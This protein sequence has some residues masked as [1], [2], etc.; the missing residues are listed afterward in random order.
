MPGFGGC[1]TRVP[2]ST[3]SA[4]FEVTGFF[5]VEGIVAV[6]APDKMRSIAV[7]AHGGAGKATLIESLLFQSRAISSRGST[8]KGSAVMITE[9][10]EAARKIAITPHIGHFTFDDVAVF[11]VDAPGYF[12]FLESTRGILPGIDGAVFIFTGI[13]GVKPETERLWNMLQ[14]AQIPVIGFVN[15]MDDPNADLHQAL[16]KIEKTL[17]TALQPLTLP[18]GHGPQF[19]GVIDLL[20]KSASTVAD[21]KAKKIDLPE[22][23]EYSTARTQLIEKIAE[24]SDVLIEKY[25]EG[26]ELSDAELDQGLRDAVLKRSFVPMLCGAADKGI[27]VDV[28]LES[29]AR[30]LPSPADRAALRPFVG[31]ESPT[32]TEEIKR[33]P[34]PEQPFSAFVIKTTIDP[35]SGKLSVVRVVSGSIKSNQPVYNSTRQMKQKAGHVYLLQGKELVQVEFLT[36]GQIGAIAKLEETHTSDT[37]CD[38]DDQCYFP[39]VKFATAPISYAVEAEGKAEDKIASGLHKLMEEDPSLHVYR[40]EQTHEMILSGMGQTHIEVTLERLARKFGGKAKLKTPRVPYRETIR[41]TVK[42]QGKLKKQSGGHG[43]FANCW[44]EVG[45]LPRDGG[46][47][48]EDQI[49]GGVIPRQF[50][51]SIKKG[52]QDSMGKGVLGGYPV[53]DVKVA[54][55]DGSYHDVDSSD[56]AFQVAGSLGFKSAL[57]TASSVLLEPIML[58]EVIVPEECTGDIMKDISSRRG[59]VLN[60]DSKGD[61][62]QIKADI[63]LAEVLDY[64]HSLSA[65]TSGRGIYTIEL[66][67]YREVPSNISEKVL[68]AQKAEAAASA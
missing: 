54:V 11:V 26:A 25:L 49:V 24:S 43:Q 40:D 47:E 59:R 30:Y 7:I 38:P 41:K 16:S 45:P 33:N 52:V 35:F 64:G 29:I 18:I 58:M 46:F 15:R 22:S 62:S 57:E 8:D 19:N 56:Y 9:P 27:G 3:G 60:L 5:F 42:V 10:E 65:M 20:R 61:S 21:G 2:A 66:S 53:V 63:P 50:I 28:L 6:T 1:A 51:P 37:V 67:S 14:D 55:Y 4:Q 68:E 31:T 39:P 36:A 32:S 23:D 17:R 48:F 34:V 44:L 13:E 12:N